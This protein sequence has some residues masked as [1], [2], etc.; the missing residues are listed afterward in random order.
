MQEGGPKESEGCQPHSSAW[1]KYEANF[2]EGSEQTGETGQWKTHRAQQRPAWSSALGDGD[3]PPDGGTGA[4]ASTMLCLVPGNVH[5]KEDFRGG[6]CWGGWE[7]VPSCEERLGCWLWLAWRRETQIGHTEE[8]MAQSMVKHEHRSPEGLW[9][10]S[11]LQW[12]HLWA[13][14]P[15]WESGPASEAGGAPACIFLW[16]LQWPEDL[17]VAEGGSSERQGEQGEREYPVD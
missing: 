6:G 7:H 10:F 16:F 1:G 2:V 9:R 13:H 8:K 12:V 17:V 14:W 15:P 5:K 11:E 4:A 3:P